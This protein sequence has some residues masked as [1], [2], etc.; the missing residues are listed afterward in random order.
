MIK[1]LSFGDVVGKPGRKT[2]IETF[3][4]V[5]QEHQP[6]IIT[7]NGENA[8]GGFGITLKIFKQLIDAE[9]DCITTGNHW[10]DKREIYS[11]HESEPQIVIP[12]NM[13]NVSEENHGLTILESKLK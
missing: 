1:V 5:K 9:V 12:A 2:L 7:V 10:A 6:D 3:K 13:G 4:S 11:F 8:A